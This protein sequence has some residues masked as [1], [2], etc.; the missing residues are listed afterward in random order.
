MFIALSIRPRATLALLPQFRGSFAGLSCRETHSALLAHLR[1][2]QHRALAQRHA[3]RLALVDG[4]PPR[5]RLEVQSAT[6]ADAWQPI[7]G[8][9]GR[10]RRLPPA[11]T[12][13][14]LLPDGRERAPAAVAFYPS[15]YADPAHVVLEPSDGAAMTITVDEATGYVTTSA[16]DAQ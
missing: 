2:A 6:D 1:Y 16:A 7:A 9:F 10:E 3:V 11:A 12:L 15:G 8:R 14:I 4:A 5:Y 13:R